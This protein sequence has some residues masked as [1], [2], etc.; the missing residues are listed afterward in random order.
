M[1]ISAEL[2]LLE[3]KYFGSELEMTCDKS[4]ASTF[5]DIYQQDSRSIV[6]YA[7]PGGVK[8]DTLVP[9]WMQSTFRDL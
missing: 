5:Y 1:H 2:D 8:L 6:L 7:L 9:I 4:D 3:F